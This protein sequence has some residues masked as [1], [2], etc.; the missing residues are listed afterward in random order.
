[1]IF[2]VGLTGIMVLASKNI[3]AGELYKSCTQLGTEC[4]IQCWFDRDNGLLWQVSCT[5]L[6]LLN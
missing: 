5:S 3:M 1:M 2:S 4:D 6:A